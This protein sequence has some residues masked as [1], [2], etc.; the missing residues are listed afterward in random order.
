MK[1]REIIITH[2]KNLPYFSKK[3]VYNLSERYNLKK[4]TIDA[5]INR[6]LADE[7]LVKLKNGLYVSADFFNKNKNNTS[8][9]FYL[10]NVLRSPSYV[11][12]WTA[13]QYYNLATEA[14]YPIISTSRKITRTYRS[15]NISVGFIYHFIKKELFSGFILEKGD[16]D[17][18]IATP[19]KA[20]FDL[21]YFKTRQLRGL[22]L[23]DVGR[24]IEEWRIDIEEMPKKEQKN[25]YKIIKKYVSANN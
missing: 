11:S 15:K 2:L 3:E 9:I 16:F 7:S 5:Y 8:Y 21:F 25:F 20:L 17:F 4:A 12:S 23:K 19:A 1:Y 6:S 24:L 22:N 14:V 18:F 10:A 13:L